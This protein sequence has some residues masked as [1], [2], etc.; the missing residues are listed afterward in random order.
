M[1]SVFKKSFRDSRMSTLWLSIGLIL[2]ALMV[3]GMYPSIVQDQ[4][5]VANMQDMM[6]SY[7]DS[8]KGFFEGMDDFTEPVNW[9]HVQ[10]TLWMTLILGAI[11]IW[12]AFASVT[13]AERDGTLDVMLS[14][15]I[16]RRE[17]LI[18]KLAATLAQQVVVITVCYITL[19]LCTFVWKEFDI[20]PF[21]LA[22]GV[23]VAF[24]P[25]I[26]LTGLAYA[27][28]AIVPSSKRWAGVVAYLFF[29][30]SYL[31]HSLA[32]ASEST[33][34]LRPYL[35]FDYYKVPDLVENGLSA[36]VI[37]VILIGVVLCAGAWWRIDQK[38]LGV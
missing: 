25:L 38:E 11:V 13:N 15:P 10:F 5:M 36:G 28:A 24:V 21:D 19:L 9:M 22:V 33:A 27:L 4:E 35:I 14:L 26:V 16:S 30:G 23:Y 2:Y 37:V 29:Y 8:I 17:M 34:N 20:P 18:G 12:Q 7:P 32:G 1:W 3:I 6:D 31:V